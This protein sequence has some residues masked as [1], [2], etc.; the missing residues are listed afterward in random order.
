VYFNDTF[1]IHR[2]HSIQWH[3]GPVCGHSPT[4]N[5]TTGLSVGTVPHP[6]TQWA[7][8]WAQSHIQWHNGPVC[9]HSPTS[10]DT[11]G[12]S[13]GTVPHPMTQWACL[14][15]QSHIQWHNGPVC[16]H[17]PRSND[18]MGL[19]VHTVPDPMTQ[20]ACLCAQS[21]IQWHNGP[22]CAHSPTSN[23]TMGLSVCT[24][25]V[26]PLGT[27]IKHNKR[28]AGW[29]VGQDLNLNLPNINY[30]STSRNSITGS[31]DLLLTLV[32]VSQSTVLQPHQRRH[33]QLSIQKSWNDSGTLRHDVQGTPPAGQASNNKLG[34]LHSLT[35][36][37]H[38]LCY[39]PCTFSSYLNNIFT[40]MFHCCV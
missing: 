33:W 4:S 36:L 15:T 3:N 26:P 16:A 35:H 32:W 10:N 34:N 8:L 31:M 37:A 5:D 2:S 18:T 24:V 38:S 7:C 30:N 27:V 17:S 28:P 19:S 1:H 6:M 14:C 23:D 11:M 22:V 21:Q 29:R 12:L 40:V 25:P 13:V 39:C 20:W 9:V